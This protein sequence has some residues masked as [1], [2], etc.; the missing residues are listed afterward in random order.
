MLRQCR[1]LTDSRRS[2]VTPERRQIVAKA[3]TKSKSSSSKSSGSSKSS[4]SSSKNEAPT[5]IDATSSDTAVRSFPD[6]VPSEQQPERRPTD[7]DVADIK[8]PDKEYKGESTPPLNAES[9]V[10]LGKHKLVPKELEGK[11]FAVID[12]P[13]TTQQDPDTGETVSYL[14]PKASI[15]VKGRAQGQVLHLPMEAFAEVHTNGRA[16]VLDFA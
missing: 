14:P 4:S 10:V 8:D 3:S 11:I 13:T 2:T 7:V 12:Y 1:R 5:T 6:S 9:W 16:S 15:T